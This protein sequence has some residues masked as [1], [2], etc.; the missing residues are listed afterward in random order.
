MQAASRTSCSALQMR[1]DGIADHRRA[2][3][4]RRSAA[5]RPARTRSTRSPPRWRASTPPTSSTRT[6]RADDRS[7]APQRRDRGR[8]APTGRRSSA[9]S[10]CPTSQWLTPSFVAT[11]LERRRLPRGRTAE[12]GPGLHGHE[13]DSVSVG[14]TTLQTGSTN[15]IPASPP[16]TFSCNFTNGGQNNET[17]VVVKVTVSGTAIS[18]QT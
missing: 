4:S 2:A 12:A 15:T 1:R 16:P 8:R 6:T 5:R 10:S 13:L 17:N 14:G 7:R 9:A 18:G 11:K 3:S